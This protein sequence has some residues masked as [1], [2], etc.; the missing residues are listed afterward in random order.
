MDFEQI[1]PMLYVI[2]GKYAARSQGKYQH[3]ELMN[4]VW[5]AGNVQ[6]LKSPKFIAKRV[7]AD[8]IDYMRSQQKLRR[9]HTIKWHSLDEK[10]W[11]A[12]GHAAPNNTDSV[13]SED[14]WQFLLKGLSR[15]DKLIAR[16]LGAGHTQA[17][18]AK[19][20]GCLPNTVYKRIQSHIRP[21]LIDRLG[22]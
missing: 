12:N 11:L 1:A 9:K 16:M 19:V 22:L 15:K 5:A 17:D 21:H 4:A 13:V 7:V 14:T 3:H 8:I 20:I 10:S 18:A 6:R 2:C